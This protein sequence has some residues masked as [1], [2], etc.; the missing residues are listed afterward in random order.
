MSNEV[1]SNL[2]QHL[3]SSFN[4]SVP[5][6]IDF[7]PRKGNISTMGKKSNFGPLNWKLG[8]GCI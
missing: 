6:V 8:K 1:W 5:R 4:Y 2:N 7:R 3:I